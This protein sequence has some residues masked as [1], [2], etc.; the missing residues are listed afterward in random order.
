[1]SV[2]YE[3]LN[4]RD[5]WIDGESSLSAD[6]ICDYIFSGK[7]VEEILS[8]N[9]ISGRDKSE[10]KKFIKLVPDIKKIPIR[11]KE[12]SSIG[13]FDTSFNI[14]KNYTSMN[15]EK[16]LVKRLKK[17]IK[18]KEFDEE[19]VII[20]V[21]RIEHEL[22]LYKQNG[23][24]DVLPLCFKIVD[25]FESNDIVWGPGRGSSCCSYILYLIGIH[26]VDSV[27]FDLDINEFLR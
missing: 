11:F 21:E 26:S 6:N 15:V 23:L 1:M 24:L 4:D 14:D 10:V 12:K 20:R 13:G 3:K 16:A 19:E 17:E 27:A 9:C 22:D 18:R 7:P 2:Y 25:T 8:D 5:L